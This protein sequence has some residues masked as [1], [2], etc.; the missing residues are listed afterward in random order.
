MKNNI[1]QLQFW[2]IALLVLV[3]F[4]GSSTYSQAV[5]PPMY[6]MGQGCGAEASASPAAHTPVPQ[7]AV[8]QPC[9]Q[10][11]DSGFFGFIFGFFRS[12]FNPTLSPTPCASSSTTPIASPE[13]SAVPAASTIQ[14][15]D[16]SIITTNHSH[17][18]IS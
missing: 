10:K 14:F 13:T 17:Q 9:D 7:A 15:V 8:Q 2:L 18:N 5:T 6:C 16:M 11:V 3:G 1:R 4:L 12:L